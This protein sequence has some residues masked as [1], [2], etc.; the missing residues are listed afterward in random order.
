MKKEKVD[1]CQANDKLWG[2]S[3]DHKNEFCLPFLIVC[4]SF[5]LQFDHSHTH[6]VGLNM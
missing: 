2:L 3:K 1:K 6:S 5:N 4:C